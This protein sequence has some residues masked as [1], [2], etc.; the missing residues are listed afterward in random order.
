MMLNARRSSENI[1]PASRYIGSPY[2]E[3]ARYGK[4]RSTQWEG[5]KVHVTETC[6]AHLPLIV[7]HVETTSAPIT[8]DAMTSTIHAE[9]DRK[10]L[11]PGEHIVDAGY[12]DAQLL[13]ESQ[14]DYKIDL[15]GPARKN[16]RLP[17]H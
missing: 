10:E 4:K 12:V 8:D 7:T 6:E 11:L 15:V 9:L 1:P 5:Y 14:R 13:V 17:S 3:E 16:S 2:D